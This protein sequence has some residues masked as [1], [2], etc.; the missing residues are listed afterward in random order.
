MCEERDEMQFVRTNEYRIGYHF[1]GGKHLYIPG[2][3]LP[4]L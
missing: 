2:V 1:D 3:E 4:W